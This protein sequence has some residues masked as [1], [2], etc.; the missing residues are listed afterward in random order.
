M[1][2]PG[3]LEKAQKS[4]RLYLISWLL[5]SGFLLIGA[6]W[7]TDNW[8]LDKPLLV[9]GALVGFWIFLSIVIGLIV[10]SKVTKPLTALSQAIMHVSPSPLP[11]TPPDLEKLGLAKELVVNLTR[12]VYEYASKSAALSQEDKN[13]ASLTIQQLPICVIAV[14][15]DS[16]IVFANPKTQE[17]AGTQ[18]NLVGKNLYSQFDILFHEET[19]LE[20]WVE[21]CREKSVT[22]Q[23]IWHGVKMSLFGEET[24][25]CDLAASYIKRTS[26][27]DKTEVLITLFDQ[28]DTYG[29]EDQG[30]SFVALA[31]HELRTPLTIL[32]GYIEM[33]EDE[34]GKDLDPEM[35]SFM[36]KMQAAA[37]NLTAFVGNILNVARI[38]QNQLSLKLT[39][40][41]WKETIT[42]IIDNM[43]LRA[44]VHG[45]VIQLSVP[46]G[47]PTVGIDKVSIAEVL[48]NLLDNSIKYS[49]HDKTLIKVNVAMT[50]D[51]LVE[52]T[53]EDFGVG[54]PEGVMP[55][56]FEKYSR[57]HRNRTSVSGTGLGL[58]LSKALVAAHGGNIWARSKD[59]E[60][61]IFGF[62]LIPY[63]QLA[64]EDKSGDNK[65]I[66]RSAH[67]WIKNHSLS[68][69]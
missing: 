52:T 8:L 55:H 26:A 61:T 32:K 60:G 35:Q 54:I 14:D 4:I 31:V 37:E 27:A 22:A 62:T 51:K 67:G 16:N 66:T 41:N 57:N 42:A 1:G 28:T 68:R 23:K 47:L 34:L 38:E 10:A 15:E 24:R 3:Y 48:I 40:E 63:S 58:Y 33:F 6:W 18:E 64:D 45:K 39:E 50:Q 25:Y 21:Q 65:T 46:D 30:L 36:Q 7:I 69:Q 20:D 44:K 49:P 43:Q 2:G 56:L 13:P 59:G 12:Q 5:F 11:I 9:L 53:V 17:Y 19:T 29:E